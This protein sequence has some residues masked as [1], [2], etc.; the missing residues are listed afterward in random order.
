MKGA[1]FGLMMP[2][3][4]KV[5]DKFYQEHAPKVAMDR[6]E[7]VATDEEL[8]VPAGTFKCVHVKETTPLESD[9]S[10]KWYAPGVGLVKDDEFELVKVEKAQ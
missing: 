5:G 4:P 8:K 9:V 7:I 1:K 2:A 6:V 10:H 3:K